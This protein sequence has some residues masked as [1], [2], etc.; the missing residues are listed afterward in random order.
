MYSKDVKK[1]W[2]LLND[3]M[4]PGRERRC[5]SIRKIISF[6]EEQFKAHTKQMRIYLAAMTLTVYNTR[7]DYNLI[8]LG[9]T[10]VP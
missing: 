2:G 8:V 4:R 7:T 5:N 10:A 9:D 3:I 1:T 6:R